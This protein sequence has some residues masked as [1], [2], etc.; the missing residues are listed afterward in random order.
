MI[1]PSVVTFIWVVVFG[2]SALHLAET[3]GAGIAET[4]TA[5]PAS[6]MFV[7][8]NQFPL[9]LPMSILTL[10]VLWIF[11]VAGADAGAVVLG[12]LSTGGPQEPRRWI[13]LTWGAA[14]AA[15]ACILLVAGGLGALQSASVL[16]GAPFGIIMVLM[17]LAF[18]MHLRSEASDSDRRGI[19]DAPP[20][21]HP[22]SKP[23]AGDPAPGQ[24]FA[25]EEP[26][27]GYNR[28]PG[29]EQPG[30]EGR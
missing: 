7:F 30:R 6:G 10:A 23:S 9:T 18:Y 21:P 3:Q 15:I 8:L 19:E 13:K 24:T 27:P 4:V 26:A 17:C 5:D 25:A 29:I 14:M 2:G 16:F 22:S 28:Q 20:A 11:Y 12:G 1:G